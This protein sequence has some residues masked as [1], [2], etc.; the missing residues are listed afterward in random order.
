MKQDY[1]VD[2]EELKELLTMANPKV[3]SKV[4][5]IDANDLG[6]DKVYHISLDRRTKF[7]PN[8]SKRA[9]AEEDNT[10]PRVHVAPNV[11]DCWFGYASGAELAANYQVDAS[12]KKV[13]QNNNKV[14][15]YKGGFYIHEFD[16]RAGLQPNNDLVYD[17]DLTNE[18]WLV[19]YNPLTVSYP[20]TSVGLIFTHHVSFY[21]RT[22]KYPLEVSTLCM[23]VEKNKEIYFTSKNKFYKLGKDI[24]EKIGAGY[25]M[26]DV[27]DQEGVQNFKPITEKDFLEQKVRS[28]ALLSY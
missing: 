20:A 28:A 21:P 12:K 11:I 26:F 3:R 24:P 27:S 14:S 15:E 25:W 7:F 5:I 17:A 18:V 22:G 6:Q 16:F 13:A 1:T 4:K 9:G 8:I 23:K 2:K 10:L 19:T